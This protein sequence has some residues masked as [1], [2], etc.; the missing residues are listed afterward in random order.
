[1]GIGFAI[2]FGVTA[3]GLAWRTRTRGHLLLDTGALGGPFL[4]SN[5][6]A[7]LPAL[8]LFIGAWIWSR[9]AVVILAIA[10]VGVLAVTYVLKKR[11]H[12]RF[13]DQGICFIGLLKWDQIRS[14]R[15][16]RIPGAAEELEELELGISMKGRDSTSRCPIPMIYRERVAE[17]LA[18]HVRSNGTKASE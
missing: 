7:Y 1:M 11:T 10:S 14:Y 6:V 18:A 3:L 2:V 16:N 15:W 17:I 4:S 13:T 5:P 8:V 12:L 9:S